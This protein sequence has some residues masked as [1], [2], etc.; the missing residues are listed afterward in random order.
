MQKGIQQQKEKTVEQS[1]TKQQPTREE[2]SVSVCSNC[3]ALL[4]AG[5]KFCAEC[6]LNV[7]E[8]KCPT[9]GNEIEPSWEICKICGQNL[10]MEVCSFCGQLTSAEDVFCTECGNPRHGITCPNC[11]TLSFRSFCR[12]CNTPLNNLAN[13]ALQE[14]R[15]DVRVK[16]AVLIV[17]ELLEI[18]EYLDAIADDVD[19]A[20]EAPQISEEDRMVVNQYRDILAAFRG[21][22]HNEKEAEP[23]QPFT[24]PSPPKSKINFNIKI[25][26][27]EEAIQKYKEKMKEIQS[28]LN[29]MTPDANLTPQMQRDYYS[30]RKVEVIVITKSKILIGWRCNAYGCIHSQPNECAEPFSGGTWIYEESEQVTKSWEHK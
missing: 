16:Q 20:P 13:L 26:N 14:A 8:N 24:P 12:K 30:A 10:N 7:N 17:Q 3:G 2:M 5:D 21:I 28:L 22:K 23:K 4:S 19:E 9:C 25:A 15:N 11:Q 29:S 18:E 6:G 1:Q 27:K